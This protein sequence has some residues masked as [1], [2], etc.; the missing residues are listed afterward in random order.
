MPLFSSFQHDVLS[1]LSVSGQVN[2]VEV[3]TRSNWVRSGR[4]S[5]AFGMWDLVLSAFFN[6]GDEM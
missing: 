3:E 1:I 4:V 2:R 6:P 5:D